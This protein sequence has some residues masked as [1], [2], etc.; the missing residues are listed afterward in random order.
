VA[1]QGSV[2][3]NFIGF[4]RYVNPSQ[5]IANDDSQVVAV[6]FGEDGLNS[7]W[8]VENNLDVKDQF[9][10]FIGSTAAKDS[11][12]HSVEYLVAQWSR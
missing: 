10:K 11:R 3:R 1:Q 4:T 9:E 7:V 5:Y 8:V 6:V 2:T 12:G